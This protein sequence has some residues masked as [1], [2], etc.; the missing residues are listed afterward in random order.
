MAK[1]P[2]VSSK[3]TCPSFSN[4]RKNFH[5][6]SDE[7][8]PPEVLRQQ[9][10]TKEYLRRQEAK[11]EAKSK[12][13]NIDRVIEKERTADSQWL[14]KDREFSKVIVPD[15]FWMRSLTI[16][17]AFQWCYDHNATIFR[18]KRLKT[19]NFAVEASYY[20]Q[21]W[22]FPGQALINA[23]NKH[24]QNLVWHDPKIQKAAL[25]YHSSTSD[26]FKYDSRVI[27]GNNAAYNAYMVSPEWAARREEA[28]RLADHRC[29]VCNSRNGLEVH[30]RS[31]ANFGNEPQT[32]LTVLC[33]Y[34]HDIFHEYGR[35]CKA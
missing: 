8:I 13:R 2:K 31:Y 32:D 23:V 26:A 30:H 17:Q 24:A 12:Q 4:G 3:W 5:P 27:L 25:D 20:E 10:A 9:E 33:G 29:R 16:D 34:C 21:T 18:V 35:L 1:R 6:G 19:F 28:L 14:D 22:L 7:P 11:R 15:W